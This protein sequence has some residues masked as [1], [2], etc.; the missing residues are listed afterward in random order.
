MLNLAL[1]DKFEYNLPESEVGDQ[2]LLLL[3]NEGERYFLS[4]TLMTIYKV[5]NDQ[6]LVRPPIWIELLS[7]FSHLKSA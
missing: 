1:L 4:K 5:E 2:D 6:V 3:Q 7:L